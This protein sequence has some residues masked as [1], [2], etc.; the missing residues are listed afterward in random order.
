MYN[1]FKEAYKI[2]KDD[3]FRLA[4]SYTNS[5]QD[6]EDVI[7]EVF[8][9]LYNNINHLNN[10]EDIKKWCIRVTINKCKDLKKSI[11]KRKILPLD[12]NKRNDSFDTQN[13]QN[14]EVLDA[15]FTLPPKYRVI[16]FLYYYGGY[17]G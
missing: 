3:M 7:Q 13:N 17:K 14:K 5:I 1:Q 15:L 11:W 10:I 12:D 6:S 16:L 4:Y 2:L 9:K 8:I